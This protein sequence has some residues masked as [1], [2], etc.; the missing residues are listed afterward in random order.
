MAWKDFMI[1]KWLIRLQ[2]VLAGTINHSNLCCGPTTA[3][4]AVRA[5]SP[6]RICAFTST[7]MRAMT[8]SCLSASSAATAASA[9]LHW[10][11]VETKQLAAFRLHITL[12][13]VGFFF[14]KCVTRRLFFSFM[15]EHM[16]NHEG[17]KPFKC[18]ECDY[19]SVY[20]KDVI[21]HSAVHSK[22]KWATYLTNT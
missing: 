18:E 2:C 22:E 6:R 21:R 16:F 9:G 3:G 17:T 5:S 8:Q 10:R 4:S 1:Y 13:F 19:S 20:K 14:L 12:L 7:L 15:Q 11:S